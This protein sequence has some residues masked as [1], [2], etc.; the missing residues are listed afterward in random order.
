MDNQ[1]IRGIESDASRGRHKPKGK[2]NKP[3]LIE[4]RIDA[5]PVRTKDSVFYQLS[6][7]GWSVWGRYTTAARR[8]QA[9]ASLVKK[10]NN[11][12]PFWG[13]CRFRRVDP[14]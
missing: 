6:L 10:N 8:E 12:Y 1:R 13:R 5:P 11:P 9:Y 14:K 4:W 3:W 2:Q 7:G